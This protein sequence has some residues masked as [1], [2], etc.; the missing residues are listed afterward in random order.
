[1]KDKS[2][3]RRRGISLAKGPVA[4]IGLALLA[5][6]ILA[7]LFR[8]PGF[9]ASPIDGNVN[10][11]TFLGI[12]G[13]GWTNVLIAGSGA[14]LLFGSPFHWGAK[15]TAMIVGLVLGAAS[16][17]SM[18][19]G[20]DV[21]GI[22]ATN[23]WTQLAL[24]AAATALLLLSLLP[25]VG[26]K[27]RHRDRDMV[28]H[29]HYRDRDAFAEERPIGTRERSVEREPAMVDERD[30]MT[31]RERGAVTSTTDRDARFAREPVREDRPVE[32]E[33]F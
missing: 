31:E 9:A 16:V 5:Y 15:S 32:R 8:Y 30:T 21:F 29:D 23:N 22:F 13:N 28:D 12:E 6:G 25:R 3:K 18:V 2:D 20:S 7:L 1:M 27:D 10:G 4:L 11:A 17:I 26:K 19:D 24:G 14:L 33:R